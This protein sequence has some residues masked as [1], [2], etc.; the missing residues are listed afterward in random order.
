MIWALVLAASIHHF[1][2]IPEYTCKLIPVMNGHQAL[3]CTVKHGVAHDHGAR[4][5]VK[6]AVG[7]NA[8]KPKT[9]ETHGHPRKHHP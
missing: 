3:L 5:R 2:P 9:L 6:A 8:L 4:R 7:G 1:P